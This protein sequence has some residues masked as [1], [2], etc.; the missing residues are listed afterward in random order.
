MMD[1]SPYLKNKD[2]I[3]LGLSNGAKRIIRFII[4]LYRKFSFIFPSQCRYVPSCS[5]YAA[6]AF[7]YYSLSRAVKLS[8]LRILRC[9]PLVKGG[10]DPL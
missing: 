6:Q 2:P 10:Y 1:D 7:L 9:N 4:A 5:E 8:F 3:T